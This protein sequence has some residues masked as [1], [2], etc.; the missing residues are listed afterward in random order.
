M[1]GVH[2]MVKK[3]KVQRRAEKHKKDSDEQLR[4]TIKF[5]QN[6]NLEQLRAESNAVMAEGG[7]PLPVMPEVV[8]IYTLKSRLDPNTYMAS[9][10][11]PSAIDTTV[12]KGG[13]AAEA[14]TLMKEYL[15]SKNYPYEE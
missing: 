13:S 15:D 6:K 14:I 11:I 4:S 8:K 2:V 1:V 10:N 3:S 7:K 5:S 12:T 9:T